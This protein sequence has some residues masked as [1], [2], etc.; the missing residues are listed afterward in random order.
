MKSRYLNKP[1][2]LKPVV[3][4]FLVF[5]FFGGRIHAMGLTLY[6]Q[7][8]TISIEASKVPLRQILEKM[9]SNGIEV[10]ADPDINPKISVLFYNRELEDGLKSIFK[11]INHILVWQPAEDRPGEFK[12][13]E[14]NI[15]KEG[16]KDRMVPVERVAKKKKSLKI[17]EFSVIIQGTRVF[18][19][20]IL[21]YQGREVN[22][23]L[24]FDTGADSMVLH[25]NVATQLGIDNYVRSK[26]RGVGG[27]E[28]DTKMTRLDFVKV[29]PYKKENLWTGIVEYTGPEHKYHNGLL[30]MN[31][32]KGLKY[33]IDFEKKT[34]K[35]L[36]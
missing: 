31:F 9:A 19:P 6:I 23:T 13:I 16:K 22:T 4:I 27:Y 12:L 17:P 7:D 14:I 33:T 21:G 28:I 26:A 10:Y 5:I 35:W 2:L 30:G 36:Q 20:V 29:G 3:L 25:E 11:S 32:L 18:V 34:I 15:F 1:G 24:L 8:N